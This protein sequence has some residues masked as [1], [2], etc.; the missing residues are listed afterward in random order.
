MRGESADKSAPEMAVATHDEQATGQAALKKG[1]VSV[2]RAVLVGLALMLANTYLLFH[3]ESMYGAQIT[4]AVPFANVI[5]ALALLT[6][7]NAFVYRIAPSVALR[8]FELLVIYAMLSIQT[9]FATTRFVFWII[10][11]VTYGFAFDTPERGW[12]ELGA[13]L[14]SWL[15]VR[16]PSALRG[17]Y[18]GRSSFLNSENLSAWAGPVVAWTLFVCALGAVLTA[19]AVLFYRHWSSNER[20]MFPV[21]EITSQMFST[22]GS[23]W[24]SR[25]MWTGFGL[26]AG[27]VLLNGLSYWIPSIPT[28]P[29]KR[30]NLALAF[31]S[32]PWSA[33]SELNL[34]F[35]P[36]IIG[37][38][39]LMPIDL[40]F[41][42][43]F[44]YLASEAQ[45]VAGSAM[46]LDAD[47]GFPFAREQQVG[48]AV[49]VILAMLWGSRAYLKIVWAG[50]FGQLD[51]AADAGEARGY[52]TAI[53]TIILGTLLLTLF[54][55][56]AGMSWWVALAFVLGFWGIGILV[57]RIRAEIGF[58][59][60]VLWGLNM[61]TILM[62]TIGGN[63]VRPADVSMLA[64]LNSPTLYNSNHALPHQME[65]LRL[66]DQGG[67][68]ALAMVKAMLIAVLVGVPLAFFVDL[69]CLYRT[70][71]ISGARY[72][73]LADSGQHTWD[74]TLSTWM[75]GST[76]GLYLEPQWTS[77]WVMCWSFALCTALTLV[78][79]QVVWFPLHPLGLVLG[80]SANDI[81]T[82]LVVAMLIKWVVLRYAGL[83][84]YKTAMPLFLGFVFGD[85]AMGMAWIVVGV[86][87]GV[88]TYT[89]FL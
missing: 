33:I 83:R 9:C 61:P 1:R 3:A 57:A 51:H 43:V 53:L 8:P 29:V 54:L 86:L 38:G 89:F 17:L 67:M 23:F 79:R 31:A 12:S 81:W 62:S 44:F 20:L 65:G 4:N 77:I 45:K 46:A 88:P 21:V 28:V 68:P 5:F 60:H 64:V 55:S 37:L 59:V 58:P 14:P 49:A 30:T 27:I 70:G 40:C 15:T 32:K 42:T 87:F 6:A 2:A 75:R 7:L 41:S 24:R 76:G 73:T 71:G 25:L 52:R 13:H 50:A 80:R 84:G 82:A 19:I 56:S 22:D 34:S 16:D 72:A 78:R 69:S 11:S 36:F 47:P 10:A 66:A 26:A 74:A 63:S 85:M 18:L 35:Y 39:F 48:A